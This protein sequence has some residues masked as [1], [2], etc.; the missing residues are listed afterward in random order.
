MTIHL[1]LLRYRQVTGYLYMRRSGTIG[2]NYPKARP[3]IFK[4]LRF[5]GKFIL[6]MYASMIPTSL[7]MFPKGILVGLNLLHSVNF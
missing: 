6:S 1:M 3:P 4:G 5:S 2:Y 7:T